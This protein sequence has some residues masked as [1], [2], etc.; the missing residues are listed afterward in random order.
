MDLDNM[1]CISVR[2]M[3]HGSIQAILTSGATGTGTHVYFGGAS[4]SARAAGVDWY[5]FF[6][7]YT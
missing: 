2:K 1:K 7:S 3:A 5:A 4:N 6:A